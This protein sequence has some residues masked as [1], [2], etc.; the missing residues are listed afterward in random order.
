LQHLKQQGWEIESRILRRNLLQGE[1][2]AEFFRAVDRADLLLLAFPLYIDSLPFLMMRLLEVMAEHFSTHP[3]SSPK[4]LFAISNNGFPEAHH[5]ALALAICQRFAIDTG[6][7]WLGGL[8][9]GAGEA[10]LGGLPLEG[11]QRA[12]RPPVKHVIQALDRASAALAEGQMVPPEAAKLMAKTPIP[13][14]PLSLWRWLFIK[15]AKQH[16]RQGA[17][18]NQVGEEELLARPYAEV[19]SRHREACA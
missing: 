1:G 19:G 11:S 16:W 3:Q 6:M 18:I 10:L 4:R 5:N 12:G 15:G 7:I 2:Q 14:M 17:A 8:A 9:L 13:W